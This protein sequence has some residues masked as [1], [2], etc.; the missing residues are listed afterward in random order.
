MPTRKRVTMTYPLLNEARRV[1][2]L[3]TGEGKAPAMR[4][5]LE[6]ES[7]QEPLPAARVRPK[8]PPLWFVDEDAAQLLSK[9]VRE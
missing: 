8:A 2:F 1:A 7:G 5:V 4:A 6:P 3:V 9:R